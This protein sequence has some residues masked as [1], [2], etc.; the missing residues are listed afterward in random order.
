MPDA[1]AKIEDGKALPTPTPP[2]PEVKLDDFIVL[3]RYTFII[4]MLGEFLILNQLGN[5]SSD[6]DLKLSIN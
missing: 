6:N 3:G 5:V 2:A 4:C 1:E